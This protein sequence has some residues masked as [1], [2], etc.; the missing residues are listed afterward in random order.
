MEMKIKKSD[1]IN[2]KTLHVEFNENGQAI[3]GNHTPEESEKIIHDFVT[4]PMEKIKNEN[5]EDAPKEKN[6]EKEKSNVVVCS[7]EKEIV[8]NEKTWKGQK[9]VLDNGSL[10]LQN[11]IDPVVTIKSNSNLIYDGFTVG[12]SKL[13]YENIKNA[14]AENSAITFNDCYFND[15]ITIGNIDV[16]IDD[17]A[18]ERVIFD[19]KEAVDEVYGTRITMRVFNGAHIDDLIIG[20][21][22]NLCV[23]SDPCSGDEAIVTITRLD[24]KGTAYLYRCQIDHLIVDTASSVEVTDSEI[25]GICVSGT[26][27]LK[28]DV[29]VGQIH[30]HAGGKV[31]AD[32]L[33]G[34]DI[35]CDRSFRTYVDKE[36]RTWIIG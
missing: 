34:V 10:K 9:F 12:L 13:Q 32:S 8:Y 15:D 23:N 16:W 26:V 28:D 2:F 21:A 18:F 29:S 31:C 3:V 1:G 33:D 17:G 6:T 14:Q 5:T 4:E 25:S 11:D 20:K 24:V 30:I 7:G 36:E 35:T 19:D 27:Y 22:N